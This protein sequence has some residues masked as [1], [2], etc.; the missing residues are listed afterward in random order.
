ME[1][2]ERKEEI[3]VE[4][5]GSETRVLW[6]VITILTL[7]LIGFATLYFV[8]VGSSKKASMTSPTPGVVR[9]ATNTP[10]PTLTLS[11][12]SEISPTEGTA[13]PSLTKAPTKAATKTPTPTIGGLQNPPSNTPKPTS[14]PLT[15]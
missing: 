7:V 8:K 11:P 5:K 15:Y 6:I 14:L 13:S 10:I 2:E 9:T 4:D 12:T 3:K 1:T